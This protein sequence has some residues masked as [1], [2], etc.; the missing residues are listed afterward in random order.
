MCKVT[1]NQPIAS[2]VT[3]SI[4]DKV[5][6][7]GTVLDCHPNPFDLNR[8]PEVWVDVTATVLVNGQPDPTQAV[9]VTAILPIV[10]GGTLQNWGVELKGLPAVPCGT[11]IRLRAACHTDSSCFFEQDFTINCGCPSATLSVSVSPNC[12]ADGT[13]TSTFSIGLTNLPTG[14]PIFGTLHLG[15]GIPGS[16]TIPVQYDPSA[17]GPEWTS[18]AGGIAGQFSFDYQ[19]GTYNNVSFEMTFPTA[20]R[21]TV[22]LSSGPLNIGVCPTTNCPTALT[23]EVTNSTNPNLP[24]PTGPND[25]CLPAGDYIVNVTQ[26]NPIG[27]TYTWSV[28]IQDGNGSQVDNGPNVNG[29]NRS[30]YNRTILADSTTLISVVVETPNC[31]TPVPGSVGLRA[32]G[33]VPP[34]NVPPGNVLPRPSRCSWWDPRCWGSLCGALIAAA[35]AVLIAAGILFIIAGCTVLTPAVLAGPVGVA[36]N[37]LVTS[38]LFIAAVIALG[39]GLALLTVWHLV[40][41]R[42]PNFDFCATLNE[43]MSF[44]ALIIFLQSALAIALFLLGGLG[45]L[46]GLVFTWGSWGTVLA[47]LQLLRNAAGC[48]D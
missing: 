5:A 34:G 20:C 13:R 4:A 9:T 44:I 28:D 25:P 46:I 35:M 33:N 7:S 39:L 19:P 12:N 42:L 18:Q 43:V 48:S 31:D 17:P 37:A 47:F 38:G 21:N 2:Q 24:L 27:R 36:L 30:T 41:S 40:C 16:G 32:C 29:L 1:I 10:S 22:P 6:V 45:C 14:S 3:G 11:R 26:P 23:I 15:S 8:P